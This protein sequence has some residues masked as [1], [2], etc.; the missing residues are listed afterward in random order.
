MNY[1]KL[2]AEFEGEGAE[3]RVFVKC[4]RCRKRQELQVGPP[5]YEVDMQGKVY[6][7]FVC[8]EHTRMCKFMGLI[9][10]VNWP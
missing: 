10:M 9:W 8:M 1:Y 4:P 5:W 6:P 3:R 2:H 7:E